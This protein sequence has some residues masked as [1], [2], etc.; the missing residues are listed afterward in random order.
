MSSPESFP[1]NKISNSAVGKKIKFL[2][3]KKAT[4]FKNKLAKVSK[5]SAH[6]CSETL[7]KLLNDTMNNGEFPNELKL[8]V[9]TATFKI[10][11]A[12]NSKNYR[13]KNNAQEEV[14]FH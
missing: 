14:Y 3:I 10:D 13:P 4:T 12:T 2:T 5:S 9:A 8:E 11:D 1:F 7:T 6:C